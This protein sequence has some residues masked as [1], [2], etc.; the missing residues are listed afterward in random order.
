MVPRWPTTGRVGVEVGNRFTRRMMWLPSGE[1]LGGELDP[2][3][4]GL[5]FVESGVGEGGSALWNGVADRSVIE[6]SVV[7]LVK[8]FSIGNPLL[9]SS[10]VGVLTRPT[11]VNGVMA[12]G[13]PASRPRSTCVF[14][15]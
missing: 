2:N 10:V 8:G 13:G 14:G 1:S 9:S 12:S 15:M 11:T 7:A 3:L 4:L 6:R 5:G